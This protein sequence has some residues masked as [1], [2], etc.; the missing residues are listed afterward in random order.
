[1]KRL[2][3]LGKITDEME[4]LIQEMVEQHQMQAHEIIGIIYL[5]LQSHC[6]EAIEIYEDESSPILKYIPKD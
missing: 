1:M 2:R 5:Y 3:P 6:P 4:P